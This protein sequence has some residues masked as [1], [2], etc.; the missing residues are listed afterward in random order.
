MNL[1]AGRFAHNGLIGNEKDE[2]Q[3]WQLQLKTEELE[4]IDQLYKEYRKMDHG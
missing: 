1:P 2:V 4:K 3:E